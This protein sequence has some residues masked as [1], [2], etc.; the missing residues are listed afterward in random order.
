M[1]LHGA[2]RG[3]A[4]QLAW[5]LQ[6]TDENEQVEIHEMRGFVS[7]DLKGAFKEIEAISKGTCCQQYLF[8]LSLNPPA[9]ADVSIGAYEAAIDLVEQK[10]G[11]DDRPRAIVFHEKDGRR[12]AHAVWSRIDIDEMKAVQLSHSKLKLR[13]IFFEHG[14]QMPRG[15][16]NSA[17]RD[18]TNYTRAEWEMAKRARR[19]PR[20]LKETFQE[21]WAISDG[22]AAFAAALKERGF[23]LARG[24]CRGY[25]AVDF[26][27]EVF[28]IPP[29]DW[30]EDQRGPRPAGRSANTAIGRSGECGDRSTDDAPSGKLRARDRGCARKAPSRT[31]V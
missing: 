21:C 6:R 20:Q 4:A 25:V 3:G 26:R 18:P 15:L 14:W 12:H 30:Q 1:I 22:K 31:G 29:V 11:L 19:D 7:D 8:S 5:H 16:V 27:G 17:E 10:L 2:Q 24:D 23:T 13:E 9:T 28:A